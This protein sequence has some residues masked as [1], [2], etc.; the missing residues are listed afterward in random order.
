MSADQPRHLAPLP[1]QVVTAFA[2]G[3]SARVDVIGCAR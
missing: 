3:A 1:G 2:C